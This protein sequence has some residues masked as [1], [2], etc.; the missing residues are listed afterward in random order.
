MPKIHDI[1]DNTP[2]TFLIELLESMLEDAKSGR[3]RSLFCV[4]GW[5]NDSTD[6]GWSMD[7]RNNPVKFV[8]A[9]VLGM[10]DFS[11]SRLNTDSRSSFRRIIEGGEGYN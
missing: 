7:D 11:I 8:G 10:Q 3:L 5:G 1:K 6:H 9:V 2:N 4:T